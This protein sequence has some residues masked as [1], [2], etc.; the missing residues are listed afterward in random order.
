MPLVTR[1]LVEVKLSLILII[2][3]ADLDGRLAG[4]HKQYQQPR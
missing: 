1:E 3:I 2:E 4:A